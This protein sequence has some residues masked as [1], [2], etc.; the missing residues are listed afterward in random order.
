[1]FFGGGAAASPQDQPASIFQ[2]LAGFGEEE[3]LF[4]RRPIMEHVKEEDPIARRKIPRK[5]VA[6]FKAKARG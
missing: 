6:L 5:D 1:M 3:R 2:G 4:V